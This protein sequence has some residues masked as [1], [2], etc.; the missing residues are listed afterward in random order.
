MISYQCR[1]PID[2]DQTIC[3]YTNIRSMMGWL[4]ERASEVKTSLAGLPRAA[5]LDALRE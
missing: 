5:H 4:R 1:S 3:D 2:S